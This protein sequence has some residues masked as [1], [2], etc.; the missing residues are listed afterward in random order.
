MQDA[1][2]SLRAFV[3]TDYILDETAT[4]LKARG[5]SALLAPFFDR[6]FASSSCRVA[7]TDAERFQQT[8]IFFLKHRDQP[9]SFTDCLSFCVM[10]ESRARE[11]LTKDGHFKAAGFLA[12]PV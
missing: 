9:W 8:R 3:T 12:L 5:Q 7:W 4:L 2:K 1:A 6:I 10:K 11:A